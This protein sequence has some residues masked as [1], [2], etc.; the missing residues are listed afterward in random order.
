MKTA[1]YKKPV[2]GKIFRKR[3]LIGL[4]IAAGL[5]AAAVFIGSLIYHSYVREKGD[6]T[7]QLA[8]NYTFDMLTDFSESGNRSEQAYGEMMNS[9]NKYLASSICEEEPFEQ[10][11]SL[12]N[13]YRLIR[14]DDKTVLADNRKLFYLAVN[15]LGSDGSVNNTTYYICH[16]EVYD[17]AFRTFREYL[18]L[19][20]DADHFSSDSLS[21]P[22]I[23]SAYIDGRYFYP[24]IS[25]CR[26]RNNENGSWPPDDVIEEKSR[27]FYPAATDGMRFVENGKNSQ[28]IFAYDLTDYGIDSEAEDT[29]DEFIRST[30]P[31]DLRMADSYGCLMT[32]AFYTDISDPAYGA[33]SYVL[34]TGWRYSFLRRFT[35]YIIGGSIGALVL[36]ALIAYFTSRL[37]YADRK[38]QYEIFTARQETTRAMA[39]DLKTPLTSIT[40][41]A[42]LLQEDIEPEKQQHYL[43]M[44]S[45]NAALMN[46]IVADILELS[47]AESEEGVL[48]MEQTDISALCRELADSLSGAFES[49]GL[50]CRIDA[51]QGLTVNADRKLLRQAVNNLLHNAAVYS[52]PGTAVNITVKGKELWIENTPAVMPDKSPEEL[53]KPFVKGESS[54]G[55]NSGSGVGLAAAKAELERMGFRLKIEITADRFRAGCLF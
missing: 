23:R 50:E 14:L 10:P 53:V 19:S 7:A 46:D 33:G 55:E 29:L 54:R 52:K 15:D 1:I 4:G 40:G 49:A 42:E 25:L 13:A 41:Y 12:Y 32:D 16:P 43:E 48:D 8:W 17:E 51:G 26:Y 18:E 11:L 27:E 39:H 47:K 5:C 20:N 45:K 21:L 35:G 30:D 44:I 9:I 22:M 37:T 36:A 24:S 34:V 2:F 28:S 3:L 31:D 38:S 6:K